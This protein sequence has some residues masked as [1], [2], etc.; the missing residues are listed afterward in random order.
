MPD[1]RPR[2]GAVGDAG[3]LDAPFGLFGEAWGRT[4]AERRAPFVGASGVL[5][6]RWWG[7]VGLRRSDFFITN[8]MNERPPHNK[9]HLF[10]PDAVREGMAVLR[11]KVDAMVAPK[12]LVPTGNAALHAFLG[13][14][15]NF[16][17]SGAKWRLRRSGKDV[18]IAWPLGIYSRRG[19]ILAYKD[20][21]GRERKLIPTLHPAATF[22]APTWEKRC[23]ADW[24]RIVAEADVAG[25]Q[26]PQRTLKVAP[27]L[28]DLDAFC[29]HIYYLEDRTTPLALDIETPRTKTTHAP[30]WRWT[31]GGC[32]GG[33]DVR[34]VE[35]RG[36]KGHGLRHG[37]CGPVT[38]AALT[39]AGKPRKL[40]PRVEYGP[41][42]VT[43][44][45]FSA[46]PSYAL[47]I[48][49]TLDYW[50]TP[51]ALAHAWACVRWL[52]ESDLPKALQNGLFDTFYLA[53]D[54]GITVANYV[55]DTLSLHHAL[56][57]SED[58]DLAFLGSMWTRE[59]YWKD[60]GKDAED[61][62]RRAA[63]NLVDFWRYCAKD[64]AVTRELV[65]V[66]ATLLVEA[67]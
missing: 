12:V 42:R 63:Y 20:R 61:M 35:L 22:R 9:F 21:Y 32:A 55:W 5:V 27:S 41:R 56:D 19:S 47:C 31:C 8:V 7:A 28:D 53:A 17:A 38:S 15:G 23:R 16:P 4:E 25:L 39:K 11:S 57:P 45:A 51:E 29:S 13:D 6:E 43:C 30:D 54:H 18:S 34:K 67:A 59:P 24:R 37:G 26:L 58:H 3:F 46:D 66:L 49:T 48:P 50:Q 65:P 36:R 1:D 33:D 10:H 60:G 14:E 62:D 44:I 52:C 2:T 64:A 40:K